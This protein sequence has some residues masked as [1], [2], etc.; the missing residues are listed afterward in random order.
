[1]KVQ[2]IVEISGWSRRDGTNIRLGEATP[3]Q[4]IELRN[5]IRRVTTAPGED[6]G[7]GLAAKVRIVKV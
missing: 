4:V 5:E 6:G 2:I 3:R 1:M 7:M